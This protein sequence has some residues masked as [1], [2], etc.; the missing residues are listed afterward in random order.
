L[1]LLLGTTLCQ[2]ITAQQADEDPSKDDGTKRVARA[3]SDYE[4][5]KADKHK[6]AQERKALIWLGEI[7]H[8]LVVDYLR[9]ELTKAGDTE[10]AAVVLDAIAKVPRPVLQP[11]MLGVL[12]RSTTPVVV[13][14]AAA[15]AIGRLGDRG[16]DLLIEL[17]R[18]AAE[19]VPQKGEPKDDA[20]KKSAARQRLLEETVRRAAIGAI[21]DSR[22]DR[23]IRA[24][25][26][27]LLQGSKAS[28]LELLRRLQSVHGCYPVSEARIRLVR[29]GEIE[30]A[31]TAWHHLVLEHHERAKELAVDVLERV[32]D[33][34]TPP[35]AAEL[36]GGIVLVQDP[37]LY[38]LLLRFGSI[39]GVVVRNALRAAAPAAAKDRALMNWLVQKGL[40]SDKPAARE[41]AKLLLLEAPVEVLQPIVNKVRAA[42]RNGS[43]KSLD[44]AVGLQELLAKDPTW[45][46]D[47]VKLASSP[48]S[49]N[50]IVA[51]SL[52]LELGSD[53]AVAI[54]QQNL[55]HRAWE[56]RSVCLR[57]LTRF[58]DTTSIPLLIER[59]EHE[60]GRLLYELNEALYVHTAHRCWSKREW[61]TWWEQH[62]VGFV[63][64]PEEWARTRYGSSGGNIK[65][66]SYYDIPILSTRVA[67]LVD[68]SGSMMLPIGTDKKVSRLDGA[69]QQLT[70]VIEALPADC[71]V[72]LVRFA[73][74]VEAVWEQLRPANAENKQDLLKQVKR[75]VVEGGTNLFDAIELAYKDPEVDTIY[76][77][78]DGEPTTGRFVATEDILDEVLRWNRQRQI[79]IHCIAIGTD[80]ELL[81][82]L[83]QE[84]GGTYK[85]VK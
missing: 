8:P 13:R 16:I 32:V 73:A 28:R 67:F 24:L 29:E 35:V 51:L 26:P 59:F 76:L 2:G 72:N 65:T 74:K 52:L 37:D 63:L 62:K 44:Y 17:A 70:S 4:A 80:A 10:F 57:Y 58:R 6:A 64:P 22:I 55:G 49:A 27:M 12:Q 60:E 21:V 15:T 45:A 11:E 47:L 25:A 20:V 14:N 31:A 43:K 82:R 30:L 9:T 75:F 18:P 68:T 5:T 81:K 84:T 48:E 39:P 33:L 46:S 34:P 3:I 56:L 42:I 71:H 23:G 36:I 85:Q 61:E 38:P 19:E 1:A 50:R 78:T 66:A 7:D 69:K 77:L 41:A 83:A 40:E 53:V 54:A 79:V